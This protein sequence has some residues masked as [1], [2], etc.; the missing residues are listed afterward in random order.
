MVEVVE[1]YIACNPPLLPRGVSEVIRRV[2]V[3]E[4]LL[5]ILYEPHVP[6]FKCIALPSHQKQ[7]TVDV[8][9]NL[10]AIAEEDV[11][12]LG[13]EDEGAHTE[14]DVCIVSPDPRMTSWSEY[15][16]R[17]SDAYTF[18]D[19]DLF[20]EAIAEANFKTAWHGLQEYPDATL[21]GLLEHAEQSLEQLQS[22]TKCQI[23]HN[24]LQTVV[25]VGSDE[26]RDI[27]MTAIELLDGMA[28]EYVENQHTRLVEL[29]SHRQ[30][31]AADATPPPAGNDPF[32]DI[33]TYTNAE[34]GDS[35]SS[36]SDPF[37]NNES[38]I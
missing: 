23:L 21:T 37:K 34:L 33:P 29:L 27:I 30:A 12:V 16:R 35:I 5:E 28:Q 3:N 24:A 36:W 11:D 20:P 15:R 7:V 4:G 25:Y 22:L 38:L 31:H 32:D 26:S 10:F 18:A 17:G 2:Q 19:G 6:W 8:Q 1:F 13:L 9:D 14:G